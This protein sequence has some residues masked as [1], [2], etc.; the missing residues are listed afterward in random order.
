M[1]LVL[2]GR[3]PPDQGEAVEVATGQKITAEVIADPTLNVV[4]YTLF[5][6]LAILAAM[7][8]MNGEEKT[9][10]RKTYAACRKKVQKWAKCSRENFGM[11]LA[12]LDAEEARL[13]GRRE[14]AIAAYSA[15]IRAAPRE[16]TGCVNR[17]RRSLR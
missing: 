9:R 8:D 11:Y 10:Q 14:A 6:G 5:T 2:E 12:L 15:A 17:G 3:G 4:I 1:V 16:G 13:D 7:P